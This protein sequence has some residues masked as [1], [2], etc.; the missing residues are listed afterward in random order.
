MTAPLHPASA[1]YRNS[2]E[3]GVSKS[4]AVMP[5]ATAPLSSLLLPSP[6]SG[7][8]RGQNFENSRSRLS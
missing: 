3:K 5:E 6:T 7:S 1:S 2:S 8:Q 4:T